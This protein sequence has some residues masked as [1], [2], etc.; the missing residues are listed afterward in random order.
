MKPKPTFDS[1]GCMDYKYEVWIPGG[2][3]TAAKGD[4]L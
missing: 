3:V 2:I 1:A 4:L